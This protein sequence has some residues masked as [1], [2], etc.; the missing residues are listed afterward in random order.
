MQPG[1]SKDRDYSFARLCHLTPHLAL[2]MSAPLPPPRCATAHPPQHFPP[3]Q[4]A[5]TSLLPHTPQ[6]R[7]SAPRY[8]AAVS[9]PNPVQ[10]TLTL[11]RT[12]SDLY[13][14]CQLWADGKEYS[15][16]F[17]TPHKDFPRGYTYVQV[18]SSD[19]NLTV[20]KVEFRCDFSHNISLL[21]VVFPD[22]IHNMGCTGVWKGYT[23]GRYHH[24]FVQL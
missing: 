6:P 1:T 23:C 5:Q 11:R 17:R 4:P 15:L 7:S 22:S 14:T 18:V 24:E 20:L 13:V 10:T 16:L 3:R 8:P 9:V 21:T 19:I 2:K 12:P